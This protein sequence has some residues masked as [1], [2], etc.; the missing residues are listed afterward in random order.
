MSNIK[1][2]KATSQTV[3]KPK[4][5]ND[6]YIQAMFYAFNEKMDNLKPSEI[7]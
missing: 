2:E 7:Y 3:A 6:H 1:T 5:G 4:D